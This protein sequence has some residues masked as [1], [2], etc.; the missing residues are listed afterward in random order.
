MIKHDFAKAEK[1]KI[2]KK[3]RQNY[4][5]PNVIGGSEFWKVS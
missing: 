3:S 4:S 1:N 2:K 5:K